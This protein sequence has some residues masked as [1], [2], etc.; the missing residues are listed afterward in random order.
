MEKRGILPKGAG[1]SATYL[2]DG[3]I[4]LS[5]NG[6]VRGFAKYE[7]GKFSVESEFGYYRKSRIFNEAAYL[8]GYREIPSGSNRGMYYVSQLDPAT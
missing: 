8:A 2:A 7:S 1:Y 4:A 5:L 3:A 6:T